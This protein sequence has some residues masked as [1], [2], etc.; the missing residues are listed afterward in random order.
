[1]YV[2]CEVSC[3]DPPA[4]SNGLV[5]S[6]S[7]NMSVTYYTCEIGYILSGSES[8]TCNGLTGRWSSQPT[9]EQEVG[10]LCPTA[11]GVALIGCPG[12]VTGAGN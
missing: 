6:S 12:H 4:I 11:A 9:C 10:A 7:S 1:M 5:D 8:I 2:D 3:G